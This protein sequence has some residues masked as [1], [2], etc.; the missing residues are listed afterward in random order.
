M[1]VIKVKGIDSGFTVVPNQTARTKMSWAARGVLVYLC[2]HT[3][4]WQVSIQDLI[5]QTEGTAKHSRRD[6]VKNI[7]NELCDLGYMRKTQSRN[8]KGKFESNDYEVSLFP[9]EKPE[10]EKPLTEKPSTDKPLTANPQLL[11]KD[12]YQRKNIT[13]DLRSIDHFENDRLVDNVDNSE[14]LPVEKPQSEEV[15][16]FELF[17]KHCVSSRRSGQRGLKCA[18]K[19]AARRAFNAQIKKLPKDYSHD[20]FAGVRGFVLMLAGDVA[21]RVQ[22]NQ[23]GFENSLHPA[24]YLNGQRWEDEYNDDTYSKTPIPAPR[25]SQVASFEEKSMNYLENTNDASQ[26]HTERLSDNPHDGCL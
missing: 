13:K 24:T 4:D 5:N 3:E 6:A 14:S 19:A 26:G 21:Q 7:I 12:L 20:G 22:N 23:M 1:S 8:T 15:E 18:A 25:Q 16:Y 11:N 2:S 10:T 9:M 17:W